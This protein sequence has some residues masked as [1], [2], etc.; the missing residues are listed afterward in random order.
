MEKMSEAIE[1]K[2]ADLMC[3]YEKTL[4]LIKLLKEMQ[5]E[6]NNYDRKDLMNITSI[7]Y[8]QIQITHGRMK[9]I[10]KIIC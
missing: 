2:F 4:T 6:N 5:Y 1:E 7:L 3:D 8:E 10:E 9:E